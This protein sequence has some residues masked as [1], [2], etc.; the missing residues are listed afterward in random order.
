MASLMEVCRMAIDQDVL[1]VGGGL[2]GVTAAIA[3]ARTG[4]TT[5]LVSA[6]QSTLRNASGLVDVLGYTPAGEGPLVDPFEVIPTLH[7]EHPY[8]RAGLEALESGLALFDEVTAEQY[9]GEHTNANALVPTQVGTVKPTARYPIGMAGGLASDD[10]DVLLVGF[11]RLPSFDAPLVA[12]TLQETP[13]PFDARGVTTEFPIEVTPDAKVT[14]FATLLDRNRGPET[15]NVRRALA[16]RIA[17]SLDGEQRVGLPAV[18]GLDDHGAV[19]ETLAGIL[20]VEVFEVPMEPPSVPGI[21]LEDRLFEAL[22]EEGVRIETG[23]PVVEYTATDGSVESVGVDRGGRVVPYAADQFVLA[24]GGLVGQGLNSDRDGVVEPL[25][26]CHVSQPSDRYGWSEDE[27]FGDHQFARFG[28]EP[29][30]EMRPQTADGDPEFDNLRA[31][32]AVL[33]N[34]DYAA[35][36]CAS[37]VSLASGFRAGTLAGEMA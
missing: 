25:F 37:G 14:R 18:L 17:A 15:D 35:E 7:D 8:R 29:D 30:D 19:R 23:T 24:T 36:K 28:V 32:G 26:D 20:S 6:K 3:A 27:A 16:E 21:R 13:V 10:R 31:A 2:A 33:G 11:E 5:R 22:D 12:D 4:A 1:V 34:Y 9:V